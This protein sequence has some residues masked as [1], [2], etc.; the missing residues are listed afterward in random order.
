MCNIAIRSKLT[1]KV[2]PF[3]STFKSIVMRVKYDLLANCMIVLFYRLV[4]D[5]LASDAT[6]TVWWER[7]GY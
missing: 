2:L 3:Q 4:K 7:Q 5:S 6:S 1:L